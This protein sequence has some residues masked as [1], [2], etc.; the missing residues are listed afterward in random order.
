[1]VNGPDMPIADQTTAAT[2]AALAQ[3]AEALGRIRF[4]DIRLTIHEGRPVQIDVTERT[5]L[6]PN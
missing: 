2:R 5:R 3:I 4:G 1:M 6:A